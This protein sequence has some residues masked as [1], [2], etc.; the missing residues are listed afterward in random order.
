MCFYAN[1]T[2]Q[3]RNCPIQTFIG[4]ISL[5]WF[6]KMLSFLNMLHRVHCS[7]INIVLNDAESFD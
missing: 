3:R 6:H 1:A 4:D 5:N 7:L 2:I